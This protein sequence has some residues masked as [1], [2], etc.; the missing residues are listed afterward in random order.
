LGRKR[1]RLLLRLQR[2]RLLLSQ[3]LLLLLRQ[4]MSHGAADDRASNRV[5]PRYVPRYCAN[6][7]TFDAALRRGRLGADQENEC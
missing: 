7:R 5:M 1:L 6:R 3:F 2:L 4:V